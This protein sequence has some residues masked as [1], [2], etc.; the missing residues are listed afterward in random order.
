MSNSPLGDDDLFAQFEAELG[1]VSIDV[2]DVTALDPKVLLSKYHRVERDLEGM[3]EVVI[4][5]TEKGREYHSRRSAYLFELSRR[6][7]R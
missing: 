6:G 5:R 1:D 2:E 4:A 7:M 3:G